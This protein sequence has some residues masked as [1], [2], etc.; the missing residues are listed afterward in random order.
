MVQDIKTTRRKAQKINLA[1]RFYGTFAE[2]G[3]GQETARH[4][5]KAGGASGSIAKTISAYDMVFSDS[6]YGKEE[7]GRYVCESRL[8]KMLAKEYQL[9]VDRLQE[10]KGSDHCF[11]SFANTVATLNYKKNNESHGWLGLRFQGAPRS[12]YNDITIHVRMLDQQN[13]LQQDALGV[14][15]VNLVYA[16]LFLSDNPEELVRSL[17]D[18][19]DKER[20]EINYIKTSGPLFRE[21]DNRVLNLQLVNQGNT[22]AVM[23][24]EKGEVVLAS[25]FL[26]KKDVL[27]TRGSYRPPTLVSLDMIK[28]GLRCFAKDIQKKEDDIVCISEITMTALKEDGQ[29]AKEDFLARVDLLS[30]L[31]MKVLI[32]NYPQYYLLSSYFSRY[33]KGNIGLVLGVYNFKQIFDEEYSSLEGGLLGSVGKLFQKNVNVYVYPYKSEDDS[34]FL[35]LDNLLVKK[36]YTLLYEYLKTLDQVKG[37]QKF[38]EKH[39][40]IYSRK[41]LNMIINNEPGWEEMVPESVAKTI[42]EK[43]LFGHPCFLGKKS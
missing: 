42:N 4:F 21:V 23:F 24:N 18:N 27:V 6:I 11:F 28:S 5:F 14:I 43:C 7:T 1:R 32:S 3:A 29:M 2:I 34:E 17:T 15:G 9:L 30:A 19:L 38:E 13:I 31:G 26:Y 35:T 36:E 12:E 37:I 10:T 33:T 39:L 40:H 25:D 20:I 22:N 41:V 8:E 16:G